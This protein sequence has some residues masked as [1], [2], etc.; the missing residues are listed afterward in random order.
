MWFPKR[1]PKHFPAKT[2]WRRP[3][4]EEIPK[5]IREADHWNGNFLWQIKKSPFAALQQ[6]RG[7]QDIR[8]ASRRWW[9][10]ILQKGRQCKKLTAHFSLQVN[11]K[12]EVCNSRQAK[13]KDGETF[14]CFHTRL[15]SLAKT[16]DFAN[17]DKEIKERIILNCKSNSLR[18]KAL[19]EDLD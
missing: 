17:P 15:R 16:C 3:E 7:W 14:S 1:F 19:R 10:Q 18:C 8:H 9:R 4:I 11:V 6:S 5:K 2:L 12:Y 13:P